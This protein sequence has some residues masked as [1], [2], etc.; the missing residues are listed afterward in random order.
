[1]RVEVYGSL[2][3]SKER[4]KAL[5]GKGI[6]IELGKQER[7]G[8]KLSFD[9]FS[10]TWEQAVLNLVQTNNPE[11]RYY[12]TVY[13]VDDC[14]YCRIMDREMGKKTA[15]KWRHHEEIC[16]DAYRPKQLDSKFGKTEIFYIPPEEVRKHIPTKEGATYVETVR[17]GIKESYEVEKQRDTNLNAL[18]KAVEES[19]STG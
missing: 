15:N 18:T 16:A 2:L 12:T 7:I 17:D 14:A 5:S 6:M 13:E 3:N 11:D 10:D 8:W 1:M 9:K 19:K 4:E